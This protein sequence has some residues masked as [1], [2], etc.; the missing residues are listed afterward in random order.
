MLFE[1]LYLQYF[2]ESKELKEIIK[3]QNFE[4]IS[5]TENLQTEGQPIVTGPVYCTSGISEMLLKIIEPFVSLIP[6]IL[7]DS[8]DFSERL[9]TTCTEATLLSSCD[10]KSLYTNIRLDV[11]YK[12]ID[13]WIEKS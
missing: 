5:I 9:D 1:V 6:H 2:S 3:N 11:F 7:K 4:Y 12:A 8:L 10:I 13:Y